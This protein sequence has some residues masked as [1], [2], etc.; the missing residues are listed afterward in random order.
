M[1]IMRKVPKFLFDLAIAL[2]ALACV[3]VWLEIKP[4]DVRGMTLSWPHSFWLIAGVILFAVNIASSMYS[5]YREKQ[6][7]NWRKLYLEE[8]Q[9]RVDLQKEHARVVNRVTELEHQVSEATK[10]D[11]SLRAKLIATCDDLSAFAREH[12]P[13]PALD[14]N[15]G[16]SAEEYIARKWHEQ[17]DY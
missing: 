13:G 17:D 14:R 15:P 12:G 9:Q 11:T 1:G 4:R 10:P 6:S 2:G 5:L 16:E 3:L 7:T 8:N